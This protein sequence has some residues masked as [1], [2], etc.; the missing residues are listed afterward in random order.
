MVNSP[1][2]LNLR[3]V[4]PL[5]PVECG[6]MSP[7][8]NWETCL[9]VAS[10]TLP[11]PS[12]PLTPDPISPAIRAKTQAIKANRASSR[13][14]KADDEIFKRLQPSA[15]GA[16]SY[17][18]RATSWVCAP[19]ATSPERA[20]HPANQGKNPSNR[21]SSR[22]IKASAKIPGV[23]PSPGAATAKPASR[24]AIPRNSARRA[25]KSGIRSASLF[26]IKAKS[27]AIKAHRASS[28][29]PRF[30]QT[31]ICYTHPSAGERIQVWACLPSTTFMKPAHQ[32]K[33]PCNRASSRQIKASAK[34]PHPPAPIAYAFFTK[35][36]F[37]Q[38][39]MPST[40]QSIS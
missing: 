12:K 14:I 21:A 28:R 25:P 13:H 17:Q 9:P 8:W 1:S 33:N 15:N 2:R 10:A 11:S 20:A 34:F 27:P 29:H 4:V 26:P 31:N 40:L 6:D 7:L 37:R 18:P 36:A 5:S 19:L 3:P 32:G 39:A 22:H 38:T 30:F 24:T 23:R 35:H 16:A